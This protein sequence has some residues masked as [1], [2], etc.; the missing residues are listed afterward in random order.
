MKELNDLHI[1][2]PNRDNRW[3]LID[4][5][6]SHEFVVFFIFYIINNRIQ[7]LINYHNLEN[8]KKIQLKIQW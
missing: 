8:N 6:S 7:V 2:R 5:D 3:I 4:K 1:F